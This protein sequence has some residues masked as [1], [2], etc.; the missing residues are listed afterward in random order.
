M[1]RMFRLILVVFTLNA[2]RHSVEKT[3]EVNCGELLYISQ[4]HIG[5]C[6]SVSRI[7]F[8]QKH[9]KMSGEFSK[10]FE[11]AFD[12][13]EALKILNIGHS[14]IVEMREILKDSKHVPSGFPD[15]QYIIFLNMYPDDVERSAR[16]METYFKCKRNLPEFFRERNVNGKKVQQ[17]FESQYYLILPRISDSVSLAYH[18]LRSHVPADYNLD[19]TIKTMIMTSGWNY[20][21]LK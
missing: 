20:C 9:R 18:G 21:D 10:M 1:F 6:G 8:S 16:R 19:Q 3:R 14:K 13:N 2:L 12:S 5:S 15:L 7:T 4:T 17:C 11:K